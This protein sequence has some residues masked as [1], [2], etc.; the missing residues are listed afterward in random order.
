MVPKLAVT[1][2]INDYEEIVYQHAFGGDEPMCFEDVG[3]RPAAS[4]ANARS[5]HEFSAGCSDAYVTNSRNQ[6]SI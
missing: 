1:T 6:N 5:V 3:W 4:A 2:G